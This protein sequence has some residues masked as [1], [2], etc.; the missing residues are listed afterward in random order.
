MAKEYSDIAALGTEPIS[1]LM[2]RYYIPAIIAMTAASLYNMADSIFIGHGVGAMAIAGVSITMPITFISTAFGAMVGIGASTLM[3]VKLG[4]KDYE[5]ARQILGNLVILNSIIGLAITALVLVWL[6][7]LLMLFGASGDTLP[8][9]RDYMRIVIAGNV[10]T[11]L[12][13]GLNDII[14]SSGHP[15]KA[16]SIT[17]T[18]VV[19]NCI[20][21]ALFIFGL[22]MGVNG[23]AW[24]T[25]IA[26]VIALGVA[27]HHF[28]S[29]KATSHMSL[30]QMRLKSH[31][32]RGI[33]YIGVA[34]LLMNLCASLVVIIINK[35]LQ[36]YG[37]DM[38]VGAYGIFNRVAMFFVMIIFGLNNGMQPI[39]GYNYGAGNYDRLIQTY[40]S[41]VIIA[42][43]VM[44][45]GFVMSI[46]A[47]RMLASMFTSDPILLEPAIRALRIGFM[48]A[49]VIGMQIITST[50]FQSTGKAGWAILLS[51]SRQM[52]LLVPLI[53]IL[54]R[55]W[56]V[57]GVW[58]SMPISD[59]I[60]WLMSVALLSVQM[61]KFKR[62]K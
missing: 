37:G 29:D 19:G 28:W 52:L 54:P 11:H 55:Y 9:A 1:K 26:Q 7:D 12:Y 18:A 56:G 31:I 49:P 27:V 14:R 42:T 38:A 13:M 17:I 46:G 58:Y 59:F 57:D 22:K 16:M 23:A 34:P 39:I 5:S 36:S 32:V 47:P 51:L 40:K 53:I 4:Q 62:V 33:L 24:A 43:V 6:D 48:M 25:V 10:V 15:T 21:N 8:Y 44:T 2:R 30:M 45:T 50:L 20:L 41:T 61:R 35:S 60:A 3:S